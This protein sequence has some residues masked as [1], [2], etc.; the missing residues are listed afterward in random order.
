VEASQRA[1]MVAA[2]AHHE[3]AHT[4]PVLPAGQFAG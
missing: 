1:P 2:S 4:E 3:E